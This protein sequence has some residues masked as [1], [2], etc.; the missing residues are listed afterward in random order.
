MAPAVSVGACS[1]T[2]QCQ[3]ARPVPAPSGIEVGVLRAVRTA[4]GDESIQGP[5]FNN[6]KISPLQDARNYD[7]ELFPG[8]LVRCVLDCGPLS[9]AEGGTFFGLR[10]GRSPARA[11]RSGAGGS[12]GGGTP[13]PQRCLRSCWAG[14]GLWACQKGQIGQNMVRFGQLGAARSR[15]DELIERRPEEQGTFFLCASIRCYGN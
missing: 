5:N 2:S 1:S 15:Q 14:E 9:S 7:M 6:R 10:A 12:A 13:P 4:V 8:N 11:P 3:R